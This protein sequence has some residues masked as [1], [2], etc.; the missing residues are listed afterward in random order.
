MRKRHLPRLYVSLCASLVSC[1][2]FATAQ[3]PNA[4]LG[5]ASSDISSDISSAT[6]H[7]GAI[8]MSFEDC[9]SPTAGCRNVSLFK[10]SYAL[11]IGASAYQNGWPRLSGVKD[12]IE[13][14]DAVFK[15]QGFET[16]VVLDPTIQQLRD[17][18][19]RFIDD[20]GRDRDNRLVLYFA[21]HGATFVNESGLKTGFIVPIDAPDPDTHRREFYSHAMS[22]ENVMLLAREI[23]SRHALFIFDS[24]FSGALFKT[25]DRSK[26]PP[27]ITYKLAEPVR[28]FITAGE[29]NETVP[30]SSIFRRRLVEALEGK[31]DANNDSYV[32]GTELGEYLMSAVLS[33]THSRQ[34][35]QYGKIDEDKLNR[36]DFVFSVKGK[37][38][39]LYIN[40]Y[41][42]SSILVDGQQV[43]GFP[44]QELLINPGKHTIVFR[45]ASQSPLTKQVTA[46][47]GDII[48]C[49]ADF[50]RR[51]VQCR[52]DR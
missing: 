43:E 15:N 26:P 25:R 13:A 41:P 52:V 10:G 36:G 44:V 28:Q 51:E 5:D 1:A 9:A 31:A 38:A 33:S 32:T 2:E 8:L 50:D 20:Y 29:E 18:I 48:R 22:M 11:L 35:P 37:T 23:Q 49:L 6:S 16:H 45:S 7:R 27:I 19:Q 3:T 40:S 21:G 24:C 17:Q 47:V 30:D 39:S 4:P 42:E 46:Q 14:I 12:D 34:H